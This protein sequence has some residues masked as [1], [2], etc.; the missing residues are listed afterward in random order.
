MATPIRRAPEIIRIFPVFALFLL[1]MTGCDMGFDSGKWASGAGNYTG[2]NPRIEMV[3]DVRG[4]VTVGMAR[5]DVQALLG[6]P[7]GTSETVD[8][9]ALGRSA[10]GVDL[11]TMAIHY[12]NDRVTEISVSRT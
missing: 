11:E 3:G 12:E 9:Y 4:A 1:T 8:R 6:P 10:V 7:D 2:E 5:G